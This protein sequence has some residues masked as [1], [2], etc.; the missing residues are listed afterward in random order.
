MSLPDGAELGSTTDKT[1]LIKGD[2]RSIAERAAALHTEGRRVVGILQSIEG[3]AIPTWQGGDG[4]ATYLRGRSAEVK[5][6]EAHRDLLKASGDSLNSYAEALG[7]AQE[8]AQSAIDKWEEGEKATRDATTTYNDQVAS[9]NQWVE[10]QRCN[11]ASSPSFGPARP[12]TF[13]DPGEKMRE[14]AKEVLKDARESL[15]KAGHS[16]VRELGGLPG[17][18]TEH[19][20]MKHAE[21]EAKG[22][23]V[24]W[25]AWS[26]TFGQGMGKD[27][28]LG[29][30]GSKKPP[31]EISLG[32]VEG[33]L[34]AWGYEGKVEDYWGDVKVNAEGKVI[35]G[36]IAG[37]ASAKIV[38]DGIEAE[39]GAKA[40][41]VRV[42]GKTGA[43]YGYAEVKAEASAE[44]AAEAKG[45]ASATLSE[46]VHVG[47]EAFAGAKADAKVSGDVAGVG[48]TAGVEGWAG[49]GAAA[50]AEV[51]WDDGKVTIG[52]ELGVGLGLG[53]K[54]DLDITIDAREVANAGGD[55]VD[56]IGGLF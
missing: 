3:M 7:V 10:Q 25:G 27:D 14:E 48:G 8:R 23:K 21:F 52:G 47:G 28:L 38:S 11:P 56:A 46:G 54:V 18:K 17:A 12:E 4:K 15:D 22:P 50:D 32:S 29:R 26:D 40:T 31:F 39:V 16:C 43:E 34:R 55:L 44:V 45:T 19:G 36:E 2:K 30:E 20:Q 5:K 53:G 41:V 49:V 9:Y 37:K 42:E 35:V 51:G 24:K 1:V 6:W 33:K 13:V